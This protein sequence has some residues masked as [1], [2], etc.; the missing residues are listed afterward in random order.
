MYSPNM[1]CPFCAEKIKD[2]AILCR[3]CGRTLKSDGVATPSPVDSDDS[4]PLDAVTIDSSIEAIQTKFGS[5]KKKIA[6]AASAILLFTG[7]GFGGYQF[8][9]MQTKK[10]IEAERQAEIEA[11]ADLAR[12]LKAA[13][14]KA[15]LDAVLDNSWVPDGYKKFTQNPYMAYKKD[16]R[17]CSS[18]GMCFPFDLVTSKYCSSVYISANLTSNGTIVDFAN[19]SANG[20]SAGTRVKMKM[21][22]T[23]DYGDNVVFVDANCR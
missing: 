21:Q 6:I 11:A 10:K 16:G 15:F 5:G 17:S 4:N 2:E 23:E 20:V 18:Y 9:E 3:F 1:K 8:N 7:L 13:E 19:D 12:K 22:W 14:E